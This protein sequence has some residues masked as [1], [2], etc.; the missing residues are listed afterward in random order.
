MRGEGLR[1]TQFAEAFALFLRWCFEHWLETWVCAY[2][3]VIESRLEKLENECV[4]TGCNPQGKQAAQEGFC[5]D[6]VVHDVPRGVFCYMILLFKPPRRTHG[7]IEENAPHKFPL[8]AVCSRED[9]YNYNS[10]QGKRGTDKA[11]NVE[12][13][14]NIRAAPMLIVNRT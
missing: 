5:T 3:G 8:G 4:Q 9:A 1:S 14:Q 13:L 7:N 11:N 2:G 12:Q 6:S 10:Y